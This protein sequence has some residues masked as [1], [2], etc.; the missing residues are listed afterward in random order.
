M[1]LRINDVLDKLAIRRTTLHKLRHSDPTFP[2]PLYLS[3][4]DRSI[5]WR[6]EDID[7]WLEGR[8]A[9]AA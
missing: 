1:L 9:R 8:P 6:E 4:S 3:D 7:K 2:K 5:R